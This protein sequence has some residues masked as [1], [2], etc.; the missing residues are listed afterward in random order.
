MT[1]P[2][3]HADCEL[4]IATLK[5]ACRKYRQEIKVLTVR[6]REVTED[7]ERLMKRKREEWS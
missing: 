3:E 6:L 2:S 4:Q 1:H 7:R 5:R